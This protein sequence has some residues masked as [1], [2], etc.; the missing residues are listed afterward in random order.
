MVR[1]LASLCSCGDID[2]GKEEEGESPLQS[3]YRELANW[4]LDKW[5]PLDQ[6]KETL[7]EAEEI[8]KSKPA[9]SWTGDIDNYYQASQDLFDNLGNSGQQ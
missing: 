7:D 8:L 1:V 4:I 9:S 6:K 3:K 2:L 5:I